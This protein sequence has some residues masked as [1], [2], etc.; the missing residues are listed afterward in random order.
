MDA[1]TDEMSRQQVEGCSVAVSCGFAER[2][3]ESVDAV[4]SIADTRMYEV[5]ARRKAAQSA[6]EA[7]VS[8]FS[9]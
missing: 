7:T 9:S 3:S 1:Y 6:C 4:L 8:P 5:K 2:Q